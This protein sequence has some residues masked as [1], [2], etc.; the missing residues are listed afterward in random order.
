MALKQSQRSLRKIG[1]DKIGNTLRIKKVRNRARSVGAIFQKLL[2]LRYLLG[3]NALQMQLNARALKLVSN[4]L[5]NRRKLLRRLGLIGK[6]LV[7]ELGYSTGLKNIQ[8]TRVLSPLQSAVAVIW[9]GMAL[10][11]I[12][13][14]G[15]LMGHLEHRVTKDN[16]CQKRVRSQDKYFRA[17]T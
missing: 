3:R 12:I 14:W 10:L 15:G 11:D 7:D 4:S 8:L 9:G 6:E 17:I 5:N 13:V 1:H 16:K 2:G